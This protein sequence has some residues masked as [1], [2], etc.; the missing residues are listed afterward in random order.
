MTENFK[1]RLSRK[2]LSLVVKRVE[3]IL[4]YSIT[5]KVRP[6]ENASEPER[7]Q[8]SENSVILI[9]GPIQKDDKFLAETIQFY[10]RIHPQNPIVVSTWRGSSSELK[11]QLGSV[12]SLYFVENDHPA[13]GGAVNVNRQLVSTLGGLKF[14]KENKL[15]DFVLKTR[16]DQRLY[17]PSTLTYCRNL[18]D[19]FPLASNLPGTQKK[20]IVGVNFNTSKYRVFSFS[21]MFQ[22]GHVDDQLMYW[23]APHDKRNLSH[24][25]LNR[26]KT[27]GCSLLD[28]CK[29]MFPE[30][31]LFTSFL[32][33]QNQAYE[34]TLRSYYKALKERMI[35]VDS[36][37]FDLYWPKY[38]RDDSVNELFTTKKWDVKLSHAEWL[39]IYSQDLDTLHVAEDM[40]NQPVS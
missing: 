1:L 11:S 19:L 37:S 14:I 23:G 27:E 7:I 5:F 12:E 32:Q 26:L 38:D 31:Y 20:R 17:D 18:L 25:D 40:L 35:V 24:D 3:A 10:R 6:A 9:Q 22:F 2:L 15:G 4:G 30:I 21:D 16:V 39:S 8:K 36:Q 13:N 33:R 29:T 34:F 28:F